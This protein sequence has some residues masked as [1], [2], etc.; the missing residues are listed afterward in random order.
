MRRRSTTVEQRIGAL[1]SSAK[2]IVTRAELIA[3]AITE[4]SIDRRVKRGLLLP[5]YPG[6][7]RVGHAAPSVEA[8]YTAAVKACGVGAVLSG[9]AGAYHWGIVRGSPPPAEVTTRGE[10]RIKGLRTRCCRKLDARDCAVWRGIPVTTIARTLV[11]L[12][13]L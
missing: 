6:V 5:A 2:G 8:D 3:T 4:G 10:R 12:S 9:L 7:Y 1:A 11:D 13:A